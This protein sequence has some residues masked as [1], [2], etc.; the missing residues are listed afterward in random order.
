[1]PGFGA[2]WWWST[3]TGGA[4]SIVEH[5]F[6]IQ[7]SSSRRT[8]PR[9]E[10]EFSWLTEGEIGFP[11][12]DREGVLGR[13]GSI[14]EPA[15]RAAHSMLWNAG[16]VPARIIEVISP[17][18]FE[19]FFREMTEL[20]AAGAPLSADVLELGAKYSGWRSSAS[21]SGVPD[22]VGRSGLTPRRRAA[23]A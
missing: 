1:M 6:E 17:G 16:D 5:P 8:G 3:D 18:G 12:G 13:G 4:V 10:D 2:S 11:W 15:R 23:N 7:V 9:R 14:A 21:R 22:V 19:H 20:V